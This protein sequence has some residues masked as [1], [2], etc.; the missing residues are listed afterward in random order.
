MTHSRLIKDLDPNHHSDLIVDTLTNGD[1]IEAI[2]I[3]IFLLEMEPI[4]G[5]LPEYQ[6]YAAMLARRWGTLRAYPDLHYHHTPYLWVN[7][8]SIRLAA[9]LETE[10]QRSRYELLYASITSDASPITMTRLMDDPHSMAN[11]VVSEYRRYLIE[12]DSCLELAMEDGVLKHTHCMVEGEEGAWSPARLTKGD[13]EAV[14]AHSSHARALYHA[15]QNLHRLKHHRPTI[16]AY[17][18]ALIS[19][20]K[21]GGESRESVRYYSGS[22][23]VAGDHANAAIVTFCTMIAALPARFR[24]EQLYPLRCPYGSFRNLVEK[25]TSANHAKKWAD[26]QEALHQLTEEEKDIFQSYQQSD[27]AAELNEKVVALFNRWLK[28][29]D[30]TGMCVEISAESWESM[31]ALH[32]RLLDASLVDGSVE[33]VNDLIAQADRRVKEYLQDLRDHIKNIAGFANYCSPS[34]QRTSEQLNQLLLQEWFRQVDDATFERVILKLFK[35]L[36]LGKQYSLMMKVLCY[37]TDAQVC[38]LINQ[39]NIIILPPILLVAAFKL[40]SLTFDPRSI[41]NWNKLL[42]KVCSLPMSTEDDAPTP[43]EVYHACRVL[44]FM[45]GIEVNTVDEVGMTPLMHAA[46]H[47]RE[48]VVNLLL[49]HSSEASLRPLLDFAL[50]RANTG[51]LQFIVKI[52]PNY[53]NQVDELHW[54]PLMRCVRDGN[55][56][57]VRI[58]ISFNAAL[59]PC[60]DSNHTALH[61]AAQAYF[62]DVLLFSIPS[63]KNIAERLKIS[64][65]IYSLLLARSLRPS[66]PAMIEDEL[67]KS[68]LAS[69]ALVDFAAIVDDVYINANEN[70]GSIFSMFY[71]IITSLY[72]LKNE[73]IAWLADKYFEEIFSKCYPPKLPRQCLAAY[74]FDRMGDGFSVRFSIFLTYRK[75]IAWDYQDPHTGRTLFMQ[76]CMMGSEVMVEHLLTKTCAP[77]GGRDAA[78]RTPLMML[79]MQ[80]VSVETLKLLYRRGVNINAAD[81]DGNNALMLVAE[82]NRLAC[83][84]NLLT[85]LQT[86]KEYFAMHASTNRMGQTA[87]Y[88]AFSQ[89]HFT[90][91][92]TLALALLGKHLQQ[93]NRARST[94]DFFP[95]EYERFNEFEFNELEAVIKLPWG[96]KDV[97]IAKLIDES[98][99][100]LAPYP[101]QS[102]MTK[103]VKIIFGDRFNALLQQRREE[104]LARKRVGK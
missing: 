87:L 104:L 3:L 84:T 31:L 50:K 74:L 22:E 11:I 88:I 77:I 53:I 1:V 32:G 68:A 70:Y 78:R 76:A 5:G 10:L 46:R 79:A 45:Q 103:L 29:R 81:I 41:D 67:L 61:I 7:R 27:E 63:S 80:N 24:E 37:M 17:I 25:L 86:Y 28:L 12:V 96:N 95:A 30:Y 21:D 44:L 97:P 55:I 57:G 52:R 60:N 100:R 89:R 83:A 94:F 101:A 49:E 8:E 51:L 13:I 64:E 59:E 92:S 75:N 82:A 9:R 34:V 48:D 35:L 62:R 73:Q 15:I 91:W 99:N 19:G 14:V 98:I 20:L 72:A 47:R 16:G 43:E 6:H 93:Y 65:G 90:L 42:I 2:N 102:G 39:H 36:S 26:L 69:M 18:R 23:A 40:P 85:V 4:E 56:E 71:C 38:L 58:L 54:S 33:S 66:I